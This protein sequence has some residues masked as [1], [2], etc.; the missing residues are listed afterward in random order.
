MKCT[1][2]NYENEHDGVF[3]TDCGQSFIKVT[4]SQV[5][6]FIRQEIKIDF[7][8]KNPFEE[9]IT[10]LKLILS[11]KEQEINR[12]IGRGKTDL[13]VRMNYNAQEILEP[14]F[15]LIFEKGGKIY[16]LKNP[17][18]P[19]SLS[20]IP[21]IDIFPIDSSDKFF[22]SPTI[23]F[24]KK[25]KITIKNDTVLKING[26][27]LVEEEG[28][29]FFQGA[30]SRR[31][32]THSLP[33]MEPA[34]EI[35]PSK[36]EAI[37]TVDFSTLEKEN[38]EKEFDLSVKND[39]GA[40]YEIFQEKTSKKIKLLYREL[41]PITI[42]VL[43]A[44]D[45]GFAYVADNHVFRE[46]ATVNKD[47]VI[48]LGIHSDYV[49]LT[50]WREKFI[51]DK[52]VE[53]RIA[54]L[55][56]KKIIFNIPVGLK[57]N[58]RI[59]LYQNFL[60]DQSEKYDITNNPSYVS[61][62]P[63]KGSELDE[64]GVEMVTYKEI[65][66]SGKSST[67]SVS[68]GELSLSD[69]REL[70]AFEISFQFPPE[71]AGKEFL[72]NLTISRKDGSTGNTVDEQVYDLVIKT[73][74][75]KKMNNFI[76]ID[77][78]TSNTCVIGPQVI[79]GEIFDGEPGPYPLNY[80][81]EIS[82]QI[83]T[84]P[85]LIS[86]SKVEDCT[87]SGPY[88]PDSLFHGNAYNN[89][90]I[91]LPDEIAG[92]DSYP[93]ECSPLKLT[94]DFIEETLA[95]LQIYFED[96]NCLENLFANIQF[97]APTGFIPEVRERISEE[98]RKRLQDRYSLL[99]GKEDFDIRMD[100][101]EPEAVFNYAFKSRQISFELNPGEFN[102][103]GVYDFGGGTTDTSFIL[104]DDKKEASLV[105]L[106]GSVKVGGNTVDRWLVKRFKMETSIADTRRSIEIDLDEKNIA[107]KKAEIGSFFQD[108]QLSLDVSKI[109]HYFNI[110]LD[111]A[112]DLPNDIREALPIK[113][114]EIFNREINPFDDL[115]AHILNVIKAVCKEDPNT[116]YWNNRTN[117]VVNLL[118]PF[119]ISFYRKVREIISD[120]LK[121]SFEENDLIPDHSK[122][123]N[124]HLLMA[125]NAARIGYMDNILNNILMISKDDF[126]FIEN[127]YV[128]LID[129]PKEAV[130]LG[131]YYATRAGQMNIKKINNPPMTIFTQVPP[132]CKADE[133]LLEPI[134]EGQGI[135]I[136]KG[137]EKSKNPKSGDVLVKIFRF[138]QL[139]F[140]P[141][142]PQIPI[143]K[144]IGSD[145]FLINQKLKGTVAG[146][147]LAFVLTRSNRLEVFR[148][149]KR[150]ELSGSD[151]FKEA[152]KDGNKDY[153][154][155]QIKDFK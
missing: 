51:D 33:L 15:I 57:R 116:E 41:V 118:I 69:I 77:F 127:I 155:K 86:Y 1:N 134:G 99:I 17:I 125:G 31:F 12:K 131:A 13:S 154:E 24:Q 112:V 141:R 85:T 100:L 102:L 153:I 145:I 152:I 136:F 142:M 40:D 74:K 34:V 80:Y 61:I 37:V 76:A 119:Y 107:L 54:K 63:K 29:D 120:S 59:A 19:F 47:E 104:V 90:K 39:Y 22:F 89:F 105:G 144:K 117:I 79:G 114:E 98:I 48:L 78:G 146:E 139:G 9:S 32:W 21:A 35:T 103:Y 46:Q 143:S 151:D 73:F 2:C 113:L 111:Q 7:E 130:G 68:C 64:H 71:L 97:V 121:D 27:L 140:N 8:I 93:G 88:I 55:N 49:D 128:K 109:K 94:V 147:K 123:V 16:S 75:P 67:L 72:F 65:Y 11:D 10:L 66:T 14:D 110:K 101:D 122:K 115:Q 96:R 138:D 60:S 84:F 36:P 124:I 43:H 28:F 38:A 30:V 45:K 4:Y 20:P 149:S 42:G 108:P 44:T 52:S 126:P 70:N 25:F 91:Y 58:R 106:G 148:F 53:D 132:L 5:C 137:G 81:H 87:E 62:S 23:G 135:V 50:N 18:R 95:N 92:E 82:G 83:E 6:Y 150:K 56:D 133:S 3:C 26:L 129:R